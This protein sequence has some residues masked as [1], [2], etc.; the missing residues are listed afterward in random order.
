MAQPMYSPQTM[1]MTS[2]L[3]SMQG[4]PMTMEEFRAAQRMGGA[5]PSAF[6]SAPP[7][8]YSQMMSQQPPSN[9]LQD[10]LINSGIASGT[11]GG[12]SSAAAG[13]T[14]AGGANVAGEAV[15]SAMNGGTM[16][17]SGM[18]VPAAQGA[19]IASSAAGSG[20]AAEG[21]MLGSYGAVAAP[22]ALAAV[23]AYTGS[24]GLKAYKKSGGKGAGKG[25]I[26]GWKQAPA[27]IKYNPV[28]APAAILGGALGGA[29]GQ[30][31]TRQVQADKTKELKGIDTN[32]KAYQD[33]I[34]G[35]RAQYDAPPPDPS[36]PFA[37]KYA[38]FDEYEKAGLEANDLSGVYGNLKLGA[39][40]AAL[41]PAERAA[42]TQTQI[43]KKNYQSKKGDVLFRNDAG[44]QADFED[45]VKNKGTMKIP[46][47]NSKVPANTPPMQ[48][49][50]PMSGPGRWV[51]PRGN[52]V[53]GIDPGFTMGNRFV[54]DAASAAPA[55]I[56]IPRSQTKS[57]GI[58][59]DGKPYKY[60][61]K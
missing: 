7:P 11:A 28:L 2:Y 12:A 19:P 5:S 42:F 38:N 46:T 13:T 4:R 57:P 49:S 29:F 20:A 44:A 15:G 10:A 32:D 8:D 1:D 16:M 14:F 55:A 56:M 43:D 52:T 53:T 9:P 45:F 21:G 23:A 48:V 24:E 30:K 6:T 25:A 36:K 54:P 58:G 39:R 34:T 22:L 3:R 33:L 27:L 35:L 60:G 26:D 37:G 17:S 51:D 61:R 31:S 59:L 50:G 47:A 41:S 40:Y 18:T